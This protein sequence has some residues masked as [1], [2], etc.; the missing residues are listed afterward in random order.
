M[1]ASPL[2]RSAAAIA[3]D[4]REGRVSAREV[5]EESI[6]RLELV[7]DDVRSFLH[8]D[9][10]AARA[11]ADAVDARV[12]DGDTAGRFLGVPVALKDN[13]C[14]KGSPTT[15]GSRI[16][17]DYRPPYD[18]T[19][20]RRLRDHG[21]VVLGKTN[22]DEFAFGS[23][24]ENS[25]YQV[26]RN[27]WDTS[28][29]AGGSSGGSA[30]AVA[31][32]IV[33][34]AL[35]SDTG[36]SIRQPASFCGTVG[37]KPTYGAVSRYG[38]IAFAS[39]LDQVGPIGGSVRD[40]ATAVSVISG[41]D[42]RDST[43][44]SQDSRDYASSLSRDIEG[45]RV[46]VHPAF[47]DDVAHEGARKMVQRAIS[48]LRDA[49]ARIVRL[50]DVAMPMEL[51]IPTYYVVATSEA[52]SNLARFDGMRYGP[53]EAGADLR[54]VYSS[55][56]GRGFGDEARRRILL[57][58]FALS[59]G[60]YDAWYDK[61]LRVRRLFKDAFAAAFEKVDVMVGATSPI[62][63]FPVG[64]RSDDPLTMYQCDAMTIPASL[65][66][67]PAASVPCGEVDG[68]PIG[69]QVMGPPLGDATVLSF[70]FAFEHL[71]GIS[72]QLAPLLDERTGDGHP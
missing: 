40:V 3:A 48:K 24:T 39:S 65:A 16:L 22:L 34:L 53:R 14:V 64:E 67:L 5:V 58:T 61:A 8:V 17:A 1:T 7:D 29:V 45:T 54:D 4:V 55:T 31:A 42:P 21:A 11:Q 59:A 18:A 49:G 68:L 62:P 2:F 51:A 15:A 60:Y 30:A 27:P 63:A 41:A 26:T 44:V 25:A 35:G 50:D 20:V 32:G 9:R 72:G 23:S 36:G 52:S 10:D 57:G 38:L 71:A 56:R 46:G 70:A 33:P 37:F 43:T 12:G 47:V 66:G 6:R 13:L 19:V 28:R 69:L